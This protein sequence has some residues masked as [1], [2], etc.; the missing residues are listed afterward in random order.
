MVKEPR[1]PYCVLIDD[2]MLMS[3]TKDGRFVCV[4]CGHVAIPEDKVFQCL[5][6]HCGAMREFKPAR[7]R[8]WSV[9]QAS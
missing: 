3:V 9:Q 6:S 7:S 4:K 1:C 5:C 8:W 2:F